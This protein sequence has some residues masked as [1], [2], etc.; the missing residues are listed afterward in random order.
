MLMGGNNIWTRRVLP[1]LRIKQ[2]VFDEHYGESKSIMTGHYRRSSLTTTY[3]V[4]GGGGLGGMNDDGPL[5][6][7]LLDATSKM[8][9][10]VPMRHLLQLVK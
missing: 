5:S 2:A 3:I 6:F 1:S 8:L 9:Y 7:V 4:G 10:D